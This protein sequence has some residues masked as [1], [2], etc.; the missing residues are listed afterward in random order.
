[1]EGRDISVCA[2]IRPFLQ[3]EIT[4]GYFET[5]IA[6]QPKIQTFEPRF[7]F[8]KAVRPV[9]TSHKV[10]YAF[11]PE[12][13]NVDVY[14]AAIVPLVDLGLRGGVSTLFAYGQTGS[15][16][17]FTVSGILEPL[18]HDLFE[19]NQCDENS[20]PINV[21]VCNTVDKSQ[22]SEECDMSNSFLPRPRETKMFISVFELLGNDATDLLDKEDLSKSV[23]ILEDKFGKIQVKGAKE[24]EVNSA[25][26]LISL[27]QDGF[28]HRKT[29]TTFKNDAS[30]RSHA[31]CKIRI[32][33][34]VIREAEDG[35]IFIVD[36]AGSENASDTQFHD[37]E[38][39]SQTKLINTSLMALKE[40]VR[41]RALAALQPDTFYHVPYRLSK[42]TLLLKDA[43]ELESNRLAKTVVI[44][45][46]SPSCA[47]ISASLS[48]LKYVGP[49]KIGQ[50]GIK[51]VAQ[52]PKNPANWSN[53]QLRT[54]VTKASKNKVNPDRLCPHESGMQILRLSEIEFIKRV[55]NDPGNRWNEKAAKE[56]YL[57]L[58][59]RLIDARTVQ[60][61]NK[62]K[63][64]HMKTHECGLPMNS[65]ELAEDM[66]K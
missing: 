30:S 37:K 61:R 6:N 66:E 49:I 64:K 26:E 22:S 12:H 42:L 43:F 21:E 52:N 4:A 20:L 25:K 59:K 48:T 2:R 32:E 56:F 40:C 63:R 10:D 9:T 36:L 62:L 16:K 1:M 60:R 13:T 24:Y 14:K 7:D 46:V 58:W 31:V 34:L 23:D 44:A 54:W 5:A 38:L 41:N 17:T 18:A 35:I 53:K 19:R 8:K 47:D 45:N 65:H 28:Q 27:V 57:L 50:I 3:Y 39:V 15:G 51:K 55:L 33:N 11:G 29:E